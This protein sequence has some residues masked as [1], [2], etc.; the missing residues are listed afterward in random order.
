MPLEDPNDPNVLM[1]GK[2]MREALRYMQVLHGCALQVSLA[3]N[4]TL[5]TA[6]G[7]GMAS[8]YVPTQSRDVV[9]V[10]AFYEALVEHGLTPPDMPH[11]D[12]I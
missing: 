12:L 1:R 8:E 5:P 3:Q 6:G 2:R 7:I 4:M 11:S 10:A 9:T